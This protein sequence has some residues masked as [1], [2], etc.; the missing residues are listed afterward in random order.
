M[1]DLEYMP[2]GATTFSKISPNVLDESAVSDDVVSPG[3]EGKEQNYQP[4]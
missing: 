1:E 2:T 3:E 4:N